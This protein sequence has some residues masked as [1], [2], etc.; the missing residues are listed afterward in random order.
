MCS[1]PNSWGDKLKSPPSPGHFLNVT[2][3]DESVNSDLSPPN[4]TA[5]REELAVFL[6]S[7]QLVSIPAG[8]GV[9]CFSE[10]NKFAS[11]VANEQLGVVSHYSSLSQHC[12]EA[13]P[14]GSS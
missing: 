5:G 11:R 8:G 13:A 12:D 1:L 14:I 4:K 3:G 2:P 9:F 7:I 10:I 6:P